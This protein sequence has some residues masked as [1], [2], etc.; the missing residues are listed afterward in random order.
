MGYA[1]SVDV[2]T[3]GTIALFIILVLVVTYSVLENIVWP[4]Y[5][6]Y[7]FTPWFVLNIA[8]VGL[9]TQNWKTTPTRNNIIGLTL[10]IIIFVLTIIKIVMFILYQTKLKNRLA[11]REKIVNET[12]EPEKMPN[13]E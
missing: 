6:L 4:R 13:L 3:S 11:K 7:M 5:L 1:C 2:S 12:T 8:L 9:I 10:L